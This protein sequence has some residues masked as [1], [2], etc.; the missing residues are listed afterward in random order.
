MKKRLLVPVIAAVIASLVGG[1]TGRASNPTVRC[2]GGPKCYPTLQA[3]V[4]AAADGDTIAIGPGTFAGGVTITKSVALKGAGASKTTIRG[5]GPV[6]TIGAFGAQTVPTVSIDGLTIT[7]GN[8]N[9]SPMSVPFTGKENVFAAGGGIEV[10]PA[11][12]FRPGA[13]LTITNSAIVGNR[14]GPTDSAPLGPPCPTGPCPFAGAFGGGID[15]WGSLTVSN[16]VLSGNAAAGVASDADGGA[17]ASHL[18][19]LVVTNTRVTG[20]SVTAV[21][22]NGRFAEGG[23]LFV[24]QGTLAVQNS[25]F[26]GNS[27]SLTSNLPA[28]VDGKPIDMNANSG[29][30]HVGDEI[31]TTIDSTTITHNTVSAVDPAGEPVAF[32]S[33]VLVNHSPLTMTNTV[34]VG[35]SVNAVVATSADVGPGG[36]A[37]EADGGGRISNSRIADNP[38]SLTASAGPAGTNGGLAVLNFS[39][40]AQLLTVDHTVISGNSAVAVSTSGSASALSGGIF[41]NSLLALSYDV[42]ANNVARASGPSGTAQGGGIWN[43]VDLSGPPVELTLDHTSVTGNAVAGTPKIDLQG[44]GLFTTESVTLNHSSIAGNTPDQCFGC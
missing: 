11:A 26:D 34:I 6:L 18:G 9:S 10:P 24:E 27:A 21:A 22:P 14:V 8:T 5:G 41:N 30:I 38:S 4:A 17:I 23:G 13:T 3:A 16:S 20:N 28:L 33:A 36:S 39:G 29:A 1:A 31:P 44:G 40:D 19:A 37:L 35:N 12:D 42:V 25:V 32:D 43:G 2:V 7:G 15:T